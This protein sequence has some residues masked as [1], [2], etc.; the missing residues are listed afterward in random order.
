MSRGRLSAPRADGGVLIDPPWSVLPELIA[1][2]RAAHSATGR[3]EIAGRPLTSLAADARA[4]LLVEAFDYTTS[5]RNAARPSG[6]RVLLAGHQPEMFHVG[7]W[8]K[9]FALA[10]LARETDSA[11]I[12]LVIDGDTLKSPSLPVPTDTLR[13]PRVENVPFDAATEEIPWEERAV[14]DRDLFGSFGRRA[15]ETLRPFIAEPLLNQAWPAIVAATERTGR[16]GLGIAQTRHALEAE[17][18][19]ETLE[20]PQSRLCDTPEFRTFAWHLLADLPR[21][22]EVHNRTLVEYRRRENIRSTHHPV[23]ALEASDVWL[24]APLWLWTAQ[25]PRRRRP[26]VRRVADEIEITDHRDTTFRLPTSGADAPY[27]AAAILAEQATRGV[28]IRSRALITTMYARLVLSDLFLHGIGGGKYDELTDLLIERYWEVPAP[29]YA[30]A[31][32]TRRLPIPPESGTSRAHDVAV[33]EPAVRHKLWELT[34]HPERSID[35]GS[36]SNADTAAR[37]G[38]MIAEKRVLT[39]AEPTRESARARCRAIRDLNGA[40]QEFVAPERERWTSRLADAQQNERAQAVLGSREYS[41]FLFP[42]RD[43]RDFLL[44]IGAQ[45]R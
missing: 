34:H 28:R 42:E 12:N 3:A 17:W 24:E 10:R 2:N 26:M 30:V 36:L 4:R 18:G 23:P 22:V 16:I 8:A 7:V 6:E 40:L 14:A 27:K 39:A 11:A 20:F 35:V 13:E 37:A 32:A 5:Y 19:L 21:F 33:D 38:A 29:S 43:V 41:A 31:T 44:A 15:A 1:H 9:N 25:D 45:G